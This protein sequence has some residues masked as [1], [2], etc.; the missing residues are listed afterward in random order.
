[1]KNLNTTHIENAA[2]LPKRVLG[3]RKL[4]DLYLSTSEQTPDHQG[5]K[6]D[7]NL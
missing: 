3:F 7:I 6:D 1:M 2:P 4:V 5:S